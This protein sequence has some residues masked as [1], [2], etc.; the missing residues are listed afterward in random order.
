MDGLGRYGRVGHRPLFKASAIVFM[1]IIQ[2][3][4]KLL[5]A[6]ELLRGTA[7]LHPLEPRHFL[8]LLKYTPEIRHLISGFLFRS[9]ERYLAANLPTPRS[10]RTHA[11]MRGIH[12]SHGKCRCSDRRSDIG[13]DTI[14]DVSRRIHSP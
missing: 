14:G 6:L 7:E 3:Q 1:Q 10:V 12:R 4:L 2:N 11:T 5:A 8:P 13:L 9:S